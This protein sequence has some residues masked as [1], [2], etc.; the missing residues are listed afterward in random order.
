MVV[1][2]LANAEG[3][4]LPNGLAE[5]TTARNALMYLDQ[6]LRQNGKGIYRDLDEV[7][8]FNQG[9][10][11][12]FDIVKMTFGTGL[13][14][15]AEYRVNTTK[16]KAKSKTSKK[17]VILANQIQFSTQLFP[18][19]RPNGLLEIADVNEKLNGRYS[20]T[21]VEYV[22]DNMAGPFNCNGRATKL[23][24]AA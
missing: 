13:I 23:E 1:Y 11:S 14:S 2:G 12:F 5:C 3:I 10:A 20:P 15:V 16:K 6:I 7:V 22:G 17:K 19:I 21:I 18:Q 9:E 4:T 8:I 24:D